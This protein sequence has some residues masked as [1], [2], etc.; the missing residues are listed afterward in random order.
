MSARV[1]VAICTWNR[2]DLLRDTLWAMSRLEVPPEVDWE[3]VV[4]DNGCTD[5]T[6]DVLSELAGALPLRSVAEPRAG[7]SHARNRAVA[8]ASGTH[9][10][11]TDDDVLVGPRWLAAYARAFD[12]H[13]EVAFFGGPIEPH[14]AAA[15]PDWLREVWAEVETL[16]AVRAAPAAG[17]AIRLDH[18]PFGANY[19]VRLD[20][21]RRVPYDTGLGRSRG[22][23][24]GLEELE[25]MTSILEAGGSGRWV[26]EASVRHVLTAD[27]LTARYVCRAVAAQAAL[28]VDTLPVRGRASALG[29]PLWLWKKWLVAEGRNLLGG[30]RRD[31]A[32]RLRLL[33]EA[34]VRRGQIEG[35]RALRG[36]RPPSRP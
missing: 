3:V 5:H 15:P 25:C 22:N 24:R 32:T 20:V 13:P 10:V 33:T 27:R 19:A 16:F 2:A 23:L 18:L 9:V 21:Q 29:V 34:G 26:P 7:L 17:T 8:E 6:G 36:T 4:V 1:T 14:F 28:E 35:L 11:W 30:W 31:A 12:A